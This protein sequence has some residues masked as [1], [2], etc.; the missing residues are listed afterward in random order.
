VFER[1]EQDSGGANHDSREISMLGSAS[2][3]E[4]RP[5]GVLPFFY[6]VM[7]ASRRTLHAVY[8]NHRQNLDK[9]FW[10]LDVYALIICI[11]EIFKKFKIQKKLHVDFQTLHAHKVV[12]RNSCSLCKKEKIGAKISPFRIF[13]LSFL[14]SPRKNVNFFTK[15][16]LRTYNMKIFIGIF[17]KHF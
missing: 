7:I 17:F 13:F 16:C 14:H 12:L 9:A 8:V 11:S 10:L 2:L 1:T 4:I 5:V 15:L 6:N 3:L